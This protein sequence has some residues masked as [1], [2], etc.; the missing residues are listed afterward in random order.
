MRDIDIS[1]FY[2]HLVKNYVAKIFIF[3][4]NKT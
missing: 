1:H 3:R 4:Y 2:Y